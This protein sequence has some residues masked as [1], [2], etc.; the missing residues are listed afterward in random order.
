VNSTLPHAHVLL[1]FNEQ[2]KIVNAIDINE[3][4]SAEIPNIQTHPT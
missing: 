4:V 2:D 1:P 3:F